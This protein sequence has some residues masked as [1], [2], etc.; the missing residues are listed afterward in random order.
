MVQ[1]TKIITVLFA[2]SS[3]KKPSQFNFA[4]ADRIPLYELELPLYSPIVFVVV[5]PLIV[6]VMV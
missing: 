2:L 4:K 1:F 6:S 3:I 5:T